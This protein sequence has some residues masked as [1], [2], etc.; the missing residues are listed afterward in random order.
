MIPTLDNGKTTKLNYTIPYINVKTTSTQTV[1]L[2]TIAWRVLE[3]F[4]RSALGYS[5]DFPSVFM[6]LGAFLGNVGSMSRLVR[7]LSL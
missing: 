6:I 2:F 5:G 7:K 1:Q 4:G 3:G